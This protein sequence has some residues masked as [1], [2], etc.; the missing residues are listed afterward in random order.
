MIV[1]FCT[2]F[3]LPQLSSEKMGT[4]V[5]NAESCTRVKVVYL[6]TEK[7]NT[8]KIILLDLYDAKKLIVILPHLAYICF[9][10]IWHPYTVSSLKMMN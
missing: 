4:F 6:N 7:K 3:T 2:Y 10:N 9:D 1:F 5:R 8:L